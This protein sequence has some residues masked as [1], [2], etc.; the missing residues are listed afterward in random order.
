[1]DSKGT[2]FQPKHHEMKTPGYLLTSGLMMMIASHSSLCHAQAPGPGTGKTVVTTLRVAAEPLAEPISPF[3]FGQFIE[4][5]GNCIYGGIWAEML[6]DRKFFHPVPAEGP[7]WKHT[8]QHARYL[9]A[10]PWQLI[11]QRGSFSMDTEMPLSGSHSLRIEVSGSPTGVF[12][13]ELAVVG[14]KPYVG[15]IVLRGKPAAGPVTIALVWGEGSKARQTLKIA[16]LTDEFQAHLLDFSPAA[17]SDNA[18]LEIVGSGNGSFTVGAVSLMPGDHVNGFRSD[19][20]ALLRQLNSPI[21]RWPGGNFVSAYDWRDG[22]GDRDR[23]PT[24]A[25]P[26]WT[27]IEPND[28]GVHEFV[29]LCRLLGAEPLITVNTGFGD[30]YS[31]AAHVEYTNGPTSTPMG[32]LREKNGSAEPFRVKFW[33]VGNEMWGNWQ[34]GHMKLDH[35]IQKQNWV[36]GM[37]RKVDPDIVTIASGDLGNGWSEGLLKGSMHHMDHIAEHFYVQ[38]K[39][40]LVEH[41]RQVPDRIKSKADAHRRLRETIPGLADQDIRIAMTE[42]NYWYGPHHF[43]ELG[44]RYFM[45]DALGIAAG[46]HEYFRNSDIIHSAFY[47]QTVNVIGA[48]KTTRTAAGFDATAYPLV[49]YRR[50]FGD[51]PLAVDGWT[52]ELDVAAAL[53][54]DAKH[55][56]LGFV[57]AGTSIH[58]V[59]LELAGHQPAGMAAAWTIQHDDPAAHNQPGEPPLIDIRELPPVDATGKIVIQPMSITVLKIPLKT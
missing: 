58:E 26:A 22:L 13:D 16:V 47:A 12:Q 17:S 37:M 51:R 25:N 24:R 44:T 36:E 54:A 15:S 2:L 5:M 18:R 41:V 46:L 56:T 11:G 49:L 23:R 40:G 45:K 34:L 4:H 31:A 3:V 6:H 14:G 8:P 39:P 53:T 29:D 52:A 33:C 19:T 48:I 42:W 1:M 21:Y 55:L 20:L 59:T 9:A 10:S 57:N 7:I 30:A 27:G 38:E 43:G 50:E 32:A 28:M 35:Y